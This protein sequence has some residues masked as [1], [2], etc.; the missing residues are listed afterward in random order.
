M[1]I[2]RL[3]PADAQAYRE[4]MLE[5]Y[6]KHPEAFTS[7]VEERAPLP[8]AWWQSRLDPSEDANGLVMGAFQHGQLVAL[9]GLEFE[10]RA[11]S[12]HKATLF[13]MYVRQQARQAGLGR[14]L[15][16]AVLDQAAARPGV[17]QV[18]LTVT[19]GNEAALSLY[20]SCGFRPFGTEPMAVAVDG[21]Y[22]GKV[23]MWCPLPLCS[24]P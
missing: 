16:R 20:R 18:L 14:A 13:G 17:R 19:E 1:P 24:A 2:R 7:S 5:A 15:V 6:G 12:R 22:L 9:A 23:H 11:K 8:L 4:L 3:V 10:S 21:R